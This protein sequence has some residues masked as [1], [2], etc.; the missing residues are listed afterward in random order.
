MKRFVGLLVVCVLF[1][2]VSTLAG[3]EIP[4]PLKLDF[5]Q[6]PEDAKTEAVLSQKTAFEF[7]ETP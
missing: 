2:S 4:V 3:E 5:L 7:I 1:N 6:Q